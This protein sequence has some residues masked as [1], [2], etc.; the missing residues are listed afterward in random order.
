MS[1]QRGQMDLG[2]IRFSVSEVASPGTW[3]GAA[4]CAGRIG[5][6]FP[7]IPG[8]ALPVDFTALPHASRLAF[9]A[10]LA[11][12]AGA[13][14]AG[15]APTTALPDD[16]GREIRPASPPGEAFRSVLDA[17]LFVPRK[18]IEIAVFTSTATVSFIEDQQIVPRTKALLG[19]EDG[20]IRVTPTI[21]LASGLR[22]DL[23]AR[24]TANAGNFASLLRFSVIDRDAY[25]T[26][27][28]LMQAVGDKAHTQLTIE[29]LHQRSPD[30]GFVG[31]GPDPGHDPRN[32]FLPGREGAAAVFQ[33]VR[34]RI[35]VEVASRVET[36]I[37]LLASS[38]FQRRLIIDVRNPGADTFD[39]TFAPGS[40]PGAYDRSERFY[41]EIAARR[42]TRAVRGPPAAGLLLE[43]YAGSSQDAHAT[44]AP[45]F[46]TG[47]RVAWFIPL[48]RS[49]TILNPRF[50]LDVVEPIGDK[51][52]PFREY[53]YAGGFR[54]SDGRV[55]RVAALAS[56]DY[57]WQLVSYV[58]AR[59]FV[60]A[61][62]VAPR[63]TALRPDH[64]AWAI[65]GGIDLHSST[66]E[67]GRLGVSWSPQ[68]VQLILVYGL[69]GPGFGDRQHR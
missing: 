8:S 61:T 64:L 46:H 36:D 37:E 34:E 43:A 2:I 54:G 63:V 67:I 60:D 16:I 55:D 56:V 48:V 38:S 22:P 17:L 58:A 11:I 21:S 3:A 65:G 1:D 13:S 66:T 23:G 59:L 45:A 69:A 9:S 50:T 51:E 26:E 20:K 47:G 18:L 42:D 4:G 25:V 41:T 29:G 52:L 49:T 14:I 7:G 12:T 53:N 62:T 10:F 28:R 33:E 27:G 30:L 39:H 5:R 24:M 40:V 44:Y 68:A 32:A 15:A 19:S 57:R 35:I 31:L 6:E